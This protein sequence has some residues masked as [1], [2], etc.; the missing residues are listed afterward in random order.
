MRVTGSEIV[1]MLPKRCLVD[2]GRYFL[3]KQK[4]SEGAAEDAHRA[5]LKDR[6]AA[7]PLGVDAVYFLVR[8]DDNQRVNLLAR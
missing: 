4:W 6:L 3:H 2:A 5:A 1:G 8:A 7:K